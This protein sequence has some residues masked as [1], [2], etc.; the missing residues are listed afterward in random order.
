MACGTDWA[1]DMELLCNLQKYVH[2]NR[3]G[4]EILDF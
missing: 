4:S 3:K 1:V 2:Q